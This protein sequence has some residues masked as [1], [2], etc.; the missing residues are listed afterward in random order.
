MFF[1]TLV[2]IIPAVAQDD[3]KA[4]LDKYGVTKQDLETPFH[5]AS[6]KFYFKLETKSTSETYNSDQISEFDPT[7]PIGERWKLLSRN[8]QAPTSTDNKYF[9]ESFNTSEKDVDAR[10]N[11]GNWSIEEETEDYVNIRFK[12]F[13][14]SVPKKYSYIEDL[15]GIAT[16]NKKTGL[17]E[18]IEFVSDEMIKKGIIKIL[19]LDLVV[20]MKKEPESG[21]YVI[22]KEISEAKAKMLGQVVSTVEEQIYSEY[23]L[24]N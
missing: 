5:D 11:T 6:A 16:I 4:V 18:K 24:V 8:G 15:F 3:V 10:L 2:M 9:N 14:K 22:D 1:L 23:K 13:S 17:L 21:I 7:R 19:E 20:Y 12:Y